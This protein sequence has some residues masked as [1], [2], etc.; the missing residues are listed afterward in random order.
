VP[1]TSRRIP[2]CAVINDRL[3]VF[4]AGQLMTLN[5]HDT[6]P[7]DTPSELWVYTFETYPQETWNKYTS[8]E[9]IGRS[10]AKLKN[11]RIIKKYRH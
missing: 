11:T 3:Y 1:P 8:P 7:I 10:L 5:S 4:D 2:G 9:A 6:Q